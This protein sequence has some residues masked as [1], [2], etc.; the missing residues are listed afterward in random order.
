MP[1]TG[2][3][4]LLTD[5]HNRP[6]SYLRVSVTDRCNLRCRYCMT[7][8]TQWLPKGAILTLEEIHRVV[9]I[10]TG[11][12][13]TKVRLTGGEPLCRKGIVGLIERIHQIDSLKDIALTTNGTLLADLAPS[14][15]QAGLKRLNISLDTLEDETFRQIT[16][17]NLWAAAWKGI[18]AALA[19]GLHPVK[20]NCVAMR[21]YNDHQ[22]ERMAELTRRFP[23]HVRFIEYMPI[24]IDPK[25]GQ[26]HFI[27]ID[28]IK[29]RLERLGQ[30]APIAPSDGDG[31]AQRFRLDDS[32]GEIGLIGSM[33][34]HFC[35]RCN[36]LRLTAD[37]HLRACLL[38][39]EQIDLITPLRQGASDD[40]IRALFNQALALKGKMHRMR[41][42]GNCTVNSKMAG[43]GG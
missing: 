1:L 36:R 28:E 29:K 31:P 39:D 23:L 4:E 24:G 7:E 8:Q 13:I 15:K 35:S 25:Q 18:E 19:E 2:K 26:K 14:L 30:L 11:L 21:Q 38:A 5:G 22:I 10:A 32:P 12:G 37:G 33:S 41:F 6:V 3:K 9:K 43:I 16:G 42:D 27:S 20:L 34:A 17:Q 40:Q